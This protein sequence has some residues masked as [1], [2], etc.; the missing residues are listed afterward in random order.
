MLS[1][2]KAIANSYSGHSVLVDHITV[3]VTVTPQQ[4]RIEV[5]CAYAT[6]CYWSSGIV[7]SA[8]VPL[9]W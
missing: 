3:T 1:R 2:L 6:Y 8:L 5:I 9:P 4:C 7:G